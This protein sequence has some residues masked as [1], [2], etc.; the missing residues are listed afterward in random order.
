MILIP[1]LGT[2]PKPEKQS[3]LLLRELSAHHNDEIARTAWLSLGVMAHSMR[4]HDRDRSEKI[5]EDAVWQLK[6]ARTESERAFFLT[7]LGNIRTRP[8]HSALVR[9]AGDNSPRLREEAVL[10]MR[11]LKEPKFLKLLIGI[12]MND[13]DEMVRARAAEALMV[14]PPEKRL[15]LAMKEQRSDPS[16]IVRTQIA[17]NLWRLSRDFP[18]AKELLIDMQI[19][20]PSDDVRKFAGDLQAR[21]APPR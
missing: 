7:V 8:V 20:D 15:F 12:F 18:E 21:T 6:K 9:Y 10:A 5:A 14:R 4:K 17:E 13:K 2:T 1:M 19:N 16:V 3:E 11:Y